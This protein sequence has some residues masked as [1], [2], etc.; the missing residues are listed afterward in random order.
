MENAVEEKRNSF[1]QSVLDLQRYLE[2]CLPSDNQGSGSDAAAFSAPRTSREWDT[3]EAEKLLEEVAYG[4]LDTTEDGGCNANW[5]QHASHGSNAYNS[6]SQSLQAWLITQVNRQLSTFALDGI[7]LLKVPF[8]SR[9]PLSIQ[10][11]V[12]MHRPSTYFPPMNAV[13][14][15]V[16]LPLLYLWPHSS[17]WQFAPV[18]V[19]PDWE[20]QR[21]SWT[22]ILREDI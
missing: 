15:L 1:P 10:A 11:F 21:R 22:T 19:R 12:Q 14:K 7:A 17:V 3:N 6:S 5:V 8:Y 2:S 16:T 18:L 13:H 4:L 9:Q 20:V